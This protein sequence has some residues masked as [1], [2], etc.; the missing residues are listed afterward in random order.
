MSN[1]D[2]GLMIRSFMS[3]GL[4]VLG[5]VV[6]RRTGS[7]VLAELTIDHHSYPN[8][9]AHLFTAGD[10]AGWCPTFSDAYD[11][12]LRRE[13]VSRIS[14]PEK[15]WQTLLSRTEDLMEL[16]TDYRNRI[17]R[18]DYPS[19]MWAHTNRGW[20]RREWNPA[21]HPVPEPKEFIHYVDESIRPHILKLN[22]LGF[23][24]MESCSGLKEEHPDRD[25]YWPYVMFDERTYPGIVPHLFTLADAAGWVATLAPHSFD[26]YLKV[27]RGDDLKKA[28]DRLV[29]S[30]A[31]VSGFLATYRH[32]KMLELHET[33]DTIRSMDHL[34]LT[35]V[36]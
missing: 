2:R 18:G 10:A 28:W 6:A 14:K 11:V 8:V 5:L 33:P 17:Q 1:P 34:G 26:V 31:A 25:P 3:F 20:H 13:S 29:A 19:V 16:L 23:G 27:K 7:T 22:E 4:R 12:V 32:R 35:R 9:E 24:T 15:E 21:P 36:D 30:A